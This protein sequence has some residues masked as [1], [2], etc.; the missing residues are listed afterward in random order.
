MTFKKTCSLFFVPVLIAGLLFSFWSLNLINAQEDNSLLCPIR[1]AFTI[2]PLSIDKEVSSDDNFSET[3]NIVNENNYLLVGISIGVGLY[4]SEDSKIPVFWTVLPNKINLA[5]KSGTAVTADLNLSEVPEGKYVVKAFLNQGDEMAVFG[6]AIRNVDFTP[7]FTL[8]KQ[9]P[10]IGEVSLSL[11]LNGKTI[12][13]KTVVNVKDELVVEGT[14]KNNQTTPLINSKIFTILTAGDVPLGGAVNKSIANEVKII[15]QGM[16]NLKLSARSLVEGDYTVYSILNTDNT[17]QPVQSFEFKVGKGVGAT[18]WPYVSIVGI[19]DSPINNNSEVVTCVN[20]IGEAAEIKYLYS[21]VGVEVSTYQNDTKISAN[22]ITNLDGSLAMFF[23]S[24]LSD[25]GNGANKL[26]V[27]LVEDTKAGK[28]PEGMDVKPEASFLPIQK[29]ELVIVCDY[30]LVCDSENSG[31]TNSTTDSTGPNQ[32]FMF[33]I[34]VTLAA[35][36]LM[37]L[38]LRRLDP[39]DNS[40]NS[41]LTDNELQ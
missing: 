6:A 16:Q 4:K 7:F 31:P 2:T 35:L 40:L 41:R 19:T 37:Y 18:S 20:Y 34:G 33:Y 8:N 1:E 24:K 9:T 14:I 30:R 11:N 3:F 17:F 26:I 23:K 21:S 5:P 13:D 27:S 38:M 39:D 36:L 28:V 32:P 25:W 29:T 22:T 12:T 10:Q 15:P